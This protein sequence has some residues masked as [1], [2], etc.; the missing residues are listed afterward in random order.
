MF[1]IPLSTLVYM[2]GSTIRKEMKTDSLAEDNQIKARTMKEA[3][4]TDLMVNI[5]GHKKIS[6]FRNF[7]ATIPS[8]SP[9][10][11]ARKNPAT[12][13]Q[14]LNQTEAKNPS[15]IHMLVNRINTATGETNRIF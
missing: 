7:P 1:L 9:A 15:S 13:R 2:M 8:R 14:K 11:S 3:T 5:K 12:I 6:T 4:G 10:A